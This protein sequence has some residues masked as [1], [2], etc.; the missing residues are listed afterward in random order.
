MIFD[1]LDRLERYYSLNQY[2]QKAFDFVKSNNLKAFEPGKYEIEGENAFLI[3]AIALPDPGFQHK[4]EAH[5]KYIDIQIAVEGSFTLAWKALE[6]CKNVIEDYN[7]VKD[8]IFFLDK[9]DFEVIINCG[10][11][12]ILM[13]EDAHF[14]QPPEKDNVKK[15]VLKIMF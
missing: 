5:R 7:P 12:A 2:F 3:I 10:C 11:F 6:D 13:P 1:K 4:L 14:P 9:G 15:G 8:A